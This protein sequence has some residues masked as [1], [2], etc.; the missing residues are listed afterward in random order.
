MLKSAK[1]Q[2][3]SLRRGTKGKLSARFAALRVKVAEGPQQSIDQLG[4]QH[5]P[6]EE[7]W[8]VCELRSTGERKYYLSNLSADMPLK[9]LA[10]AIKVR[11]VCE[12]AH[13]QLK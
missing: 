13:Q 1:W 2:T 10:G 11:W 7:V 8:L 6:G 5:L 9:K 3:V 4:Q 12:L